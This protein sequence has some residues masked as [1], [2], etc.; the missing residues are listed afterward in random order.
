M[1]EINKSILDEIPENHH[2]VFC[3]LGLASEEREKL[4]YWEKWQRLYHYINPILPHLPYKKLQ[5]P[6]NELLP[7][8]VF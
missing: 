7:C 8:E 1:N 4:Y 3:F 6:I 2:L 5:Y